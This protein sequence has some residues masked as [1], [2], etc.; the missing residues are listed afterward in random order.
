MRAISNLVEK[1]NEVR[2]RGRAGA[3]RDGWG[4]SGDVRVLDRGPAFTQAQRTRVFEQFSRG[5]TSSGGGGGSG[6]A[7]RKGFVEAKAAARAGGHRRGHGGP[8]GRLPCHDRLARPIGRKTSRQ[9]LS[10]P[11][12]PCA[13]RGLPGTTWPATVAEASTRSR[14]PA[15]R[16]RARPSVPD[17]TGVDSA[18]RT[19]AAGRALPVWYCRPSAT[20]GEGRA[21]RRGAQT[22]YSP[23]LRRR[24]ASP[25]AERAAAQ[26]GRLPPGVRDG[27]RAGGR[28]DRPAARRVDQG[29]PRGSTSPSSVRT[30]C[31]RG[32]NR[33]Q[34]R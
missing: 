33:G 10:G 32:H 7:N 29:R 11:E 22:D 13:P 26:C 30:S 1:R 25:P 28:R 15:R 9:I 23:A 34:A 24:R 20:S 5:R 12:R 4:E 18:A 31:A 21:T 27:D 19:C 14:A 8:P 6:L 2:A 3:L 17:G 16:A